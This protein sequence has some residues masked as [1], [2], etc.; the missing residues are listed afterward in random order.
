[1]I[2]RSSRYS[3]VLPQDDCSL[4]PASIDNALYTD[5]IHMPLHGLQDWLIHANTCPYRLCVCV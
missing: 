2:T 4:T 1:L 3:L 5:P